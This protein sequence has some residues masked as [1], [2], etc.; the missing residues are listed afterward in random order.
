MSFESIDSKYIN[1]L[2]SSGIVDAYEYVLRKLIQDNLPRNQVYEKCARYLLEYQKLLLEN[3]IRAKNAQSFFNLANFEEEKKKEI[4]AKEIIPTFPIVL[5]SRLLFEQE[6]NRPPQKIF[7]TNIDELMKNKLNLLSKNALN[8]QMRANIKG[9]GSYATFVENENENLRRY[10][11]KINTKFNNFQF[12]HMEEIEKGNYPTEDINFENNNKNL[13]N[14]NNNTLNNNNI[15]LNSDTEFIMPIGEGRMNT[16]T[17]RKTSK[18]SKKTESESISSKSIT[19]SQQSRI[20]KESK[21]MAN[22]L[23]K[24]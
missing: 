18:R 15:N 13:N 19:P 1:T 8:E 16:Q 2:E 23:M 7:E 14:Y 3:N 10:D 24:K 22:E 11:F 12:T 21:A 5:W 4:K 9:Y 20:K 17:S 6:E